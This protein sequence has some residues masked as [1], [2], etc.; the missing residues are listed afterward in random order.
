MEVAVGIDELNWFGPTVEPFV[1]PIRKLFDKHCTTDYCSSFSYIDFALHVGEKGGVGRVGLSQRA[2][3]IGIDILLDIEP[4]QFPESVAER[5]VSG[6]KEAAGK[7]VKRMHR[8]EFDFDGEAFRAEF[9]A[10]IAE[11]EATVL[12]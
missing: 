7:I 8:S 10:A 6:L 2:S 1:L 4:D 11:Y 12:S 5:I 9:D 3:S